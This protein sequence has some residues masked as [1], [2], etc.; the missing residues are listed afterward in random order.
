[1]HDAHLSWVTEPWYMRLFLLYLVIVGCVALMGG[2]KL[3]RL[4]YSFTRRKRLSLGD[5]RDDITVEDLTVRLALAD[6]IVY[7]P[8]AVPSFA[9][10]DA[11]TPSRNSSRWLPPDAISEIRF[12]Q[13]L[14][15]T[16][17]AVLA[18]PMEHKSVSTPALGRIV[19]GL[20]GNYSTLPALHTLA[21][22][23]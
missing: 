13:M 12:R 10:T 11:T 8:V 18:H 1:M 16:V 7:E 22:A 19:P 3:A 5:I 2:L 9:H 21:A 23:L 4:L 20:R 6:K 15:Q 14:A 17:D